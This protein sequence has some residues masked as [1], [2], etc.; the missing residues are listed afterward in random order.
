[1][2]AFA[3]SSNSNLWV[4]RHLTSERLPNLSVRWQK[5]VDIADEPLKPDRVAASTDLLTDGFN[6][7]RALVHN[8]PAGLSLQTIEGAQTSRKQHGA[9][10]RDAESIVTGR[11]YQFLSGEPL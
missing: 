5:S 4:N 3:T 7:R 9:H 11:D 8:N 2:S 1:M 10:V 6:A